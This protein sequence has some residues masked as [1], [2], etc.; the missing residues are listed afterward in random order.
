MTM[1]M[2]SIAPTLKSAVSQ[3]GMSFRTTQR[4]T[5]RVTS[6]KIGWKNPPMK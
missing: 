5:L 2:P 3:D 1:R 4:D 6:Q